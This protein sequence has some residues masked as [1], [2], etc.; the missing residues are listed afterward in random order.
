KAHRIAP[1]RWFFRTFPQT[2]RKHAAGF[3]LAVALTIVGF[4]FG[5]GALAWDPD[6]K[7]V[8]MPFPQLQQSPVDR[9]R[10][11]EKAEKD[12]LAGHKSSFSAFLM[13]HNTKV[14]ILTLA[15]GM[16][17]GVGTLLLL[18]YNG[19]MIG[20]VS[21]DYVLAGQTKFLLGWL[22]PH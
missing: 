20:A 15:M 1:L 3:W 19:V 2:F 12:R 22:M 21:L 9:V 16:T 14:A 13:T 18:F 4:A 5:G 11:E 17:W 10:E 6:A 8:L 7:A